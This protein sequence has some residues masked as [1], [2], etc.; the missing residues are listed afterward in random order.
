MVDNGRDRGQLLL[1]GAVAIAFMIL[2]VVV[3]F[4]GV[5]YTQTISAGGTTTETNDVATTELEVERAAGCLLYRTAGE[6]EFRKNFTEFVDSYRNST[7]GSGPT[8]VASE[9]RVYDDRG[10]VELGVVYDSSDVTSERTLVVYQNACPSVELPFD[11]VGDCNEVEDGNLHE[12]IIVECDVGDSNGDIDSIDMDDRAILIGDI[13]D[14]DDASFDAE[15][16][17]TGYISAGNNIN[18]H[19]GSE[20]WGTVTAKDKVDLDDGSV[21]RGDI[22]SED[23]NIDLDD[24]SLVEGDVVSK[25]GTVNL[26]GGSAVRGDVYVGGDLECNDDGSTINGVPCDEYEPKSPEDYE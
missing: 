20:I 24:G 14:V 13:D 3:V 1:V 4:N 10:I 26:D 15:S 9:V 21:V 23:E 25:D 7:A 17:V 22:V 18:I 19:G 16:I 8:L 2:G 5:L 12:G 6:S 11:P